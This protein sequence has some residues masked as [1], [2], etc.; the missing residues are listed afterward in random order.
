METQRENTVRGD[1]SILS[2]SYL[3]P[4]GIPALDPPVGQ[5]TESGGGERVVSLAGWPGGLG[6][7]KCPSPYKYKGISKTPLSVTGCIKIKR[8]S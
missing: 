2:R 6:L 1:V 3:L 5:G 7:G 8:V 4:Q